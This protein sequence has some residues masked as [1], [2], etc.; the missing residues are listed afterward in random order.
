MSRGG[1]SASQAAG[2]RPAV[3]IRDVAAMAEVH[4]GTVSRALNEETR[5]LVNLETAERVLEAAH[6]LGYRPNRIARGLKTSRSY[7]VGVL[8]PEITNPLFPPI[9]R[10]IEDTHDPLI[11]RHLVEAVGAERVLLGSGYPFD[12]ADRRPAETVRRAGL[13]AE[14]E[15]TLLHDNAERLLVSAKV[16]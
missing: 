11:L 13:A 8:V 16:S 14:D 5:A 4:P 10:G 12:M 6:K 7:T 1:R 2:P 3:T 15:A 9:V